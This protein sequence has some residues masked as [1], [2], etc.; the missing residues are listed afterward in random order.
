MLRVLRGCVLRVLRGCVH[1]ALQACVLRGLRCVQNSAADVLGPALAWGG[2]VE[3]EV[4]ATL[5]LKAS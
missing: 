1:R 4:A 2:V 5:K 3:E